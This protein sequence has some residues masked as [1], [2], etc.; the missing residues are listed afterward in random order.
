MSASDSNPRYSKPSASCSETKPGASPVH[1]AAQAVKHG[2]LSLGYGG[3]RCP[4]TNVPSLAAVRENSDLP[5]DLAP[6]ADGVLQKLFHRV[7]IGPGPPRD[8]L[9]EIGNT[10]GTERCS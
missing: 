5:N 9:H 10:I 7:L 8:L 4:N 2:Q 3:S 6:L 1:S